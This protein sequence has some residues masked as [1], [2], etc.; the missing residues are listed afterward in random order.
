MTVTI[1]AL[2]FIIFVLGITIFGFKAVI[3]QGK[4]PGDLHK[5]RCSICREQFVKSQLIEREVGDHRVYFFCP[6][7]INKLHGELVSKN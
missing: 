5:E 7:C 4:A 2:V 6:S 3:K 1:L